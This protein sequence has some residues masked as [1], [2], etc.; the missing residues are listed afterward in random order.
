MHIHSHAVRLT[1][2]VLLASLASGLSGCGESDPSP[3][4]DP[5]TQ[6]G[7]VL[8][9]EIEP[10]Q[11]RVGATALTLVLTNTGSDK[12]DIGLGG[13]GPPSWGGAFNLIVV[14]IA[15]NEVWR[16]STGPVLLQLIPVSLEPGEQMMFEGEW[17]GEGVGGRP[18]AGRIYRVY[19]RMQITLDPN[20]AGE[21]IEL[22]TETYDL[23]V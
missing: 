8:T 17:D 15:G 11:T 4:P 19:G 12:V 1:A 23:E 6:H 13:A 3:T 18:V 7:L 9:L 21:S 2:A 20:G 5:T 14:D 10:P 16:W 22:V